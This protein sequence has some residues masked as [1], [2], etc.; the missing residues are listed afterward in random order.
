[1]QKKYNPMKA[2]SGIGRKGK[3]GRCSFLCVVEVLEKKVGKSN[4]KNL[5]GSNE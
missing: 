3:T 2:Y 5:R 4:Q 1:M